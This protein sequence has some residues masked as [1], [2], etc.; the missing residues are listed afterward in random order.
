LANRL[1]GPVGSPPAAG[2]A[3]CADPVDR[4][5]PPV[6][7]CSLLPDV[8]TDADAGRPAPALPRP[9]EVEGTDA[10]AV[11]RVAAVV[12][13]DCDQPASVNCGV[14]PE[15]PGEASPD[16]WMV[17]AGA[18][19]T[20]KSPPR[21]P[22]IAPAA[23]HASPPDATT[24]KVRRPFHFAGRSGAAWAAWRAWARRAGGVAVAA[25]ARRGFDRVGC[26]CGR[27]FC[28]GSGTATTGTATTG[29]GTGGRNSSCTMAAIT[30]LRFMAFLPS[31]NVH[32]PT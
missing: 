29:T 14:C 22:M 20:E 1:V 17:W 12:R 18:G 5:A 3:G 2:G 10:P 27:G 26:G 6:L 8:D 7:T 16:V 21:P 25:E 11:R 15:A 30:S 9:R 24:A 32:G 19:A 28:T 13:P 23:A 4:P 31:P